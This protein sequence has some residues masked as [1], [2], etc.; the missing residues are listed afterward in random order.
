MSP[1]GFKTGVSTVQWLHIEPKWRA[2][3]ICWLI[4]ENIGLHGWMYDCYVTTKTFK[5]M[6]TWSELNPIF[7]GFIQIMACNMCDDEN[8]DS[9][10]KFTYLF[11]FI[12]HWSLS[13]YQFFSWL[14]L[15]CSSE[16]EINLSLCCKIMNPGHQQ[17]LLLLCF[18]TD[19][20][21]FTHALQGVL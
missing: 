17:F 7:P 21:L 10:S 13:K 11:N 20:W 2:C 15:Q 18:D 9:D 12:T 19:A 16:F 3:D 4:V 6:V 14:R 1:G 5:I 8:T